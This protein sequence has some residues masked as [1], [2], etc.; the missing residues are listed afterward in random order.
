MEINRNVGTLG[1]EMTGKNFFELTQGNFSSSATSSVIAVSLEEP[2]GGAA[3]NFVR[4]TCK[5]CGDS[6]F[7][8]THWGVRA[9][10][11][12]TPPAVRGMVGCQYFFDDQGIRWDVTNEDGW[13]RWRRDRSTIV[14]RWSPWPEN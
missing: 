10:L 4:P 7:W 11:L 9:C 1:T 14:R 5:N 12:C 6:E 8:E 2:A 13:E 3:K